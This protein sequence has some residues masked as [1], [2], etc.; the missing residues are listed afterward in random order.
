MKTFGDNLKNIRKELKLTQKQFGE[1]IG[2]DS[3]TVCSWEKSRNTPSLYSV[4]KI[5][6]VFNI[7]LYELFDFDEEE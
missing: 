3:R 2:Y 4:K 1:K 7:D 5:C 6:K